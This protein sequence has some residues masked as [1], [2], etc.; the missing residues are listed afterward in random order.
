L[1]GDYAGWAQTIMFIDDLKGFQKEK[2]NS[3]LVKCES[4]P[5]L[6]T[7]LKKEPI[8]EPIIKEER[9]DEHDNRKGKKRPNITG[10][11]K[12]PKNFKKK[13]SI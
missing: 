7:N 11:D 10:V 6:L 9:V 13:K 1:W 12:L 2:S 8:E 5:N 4:Q 3:L